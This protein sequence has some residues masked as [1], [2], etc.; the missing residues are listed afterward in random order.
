MTADEEY[1]LVSEM[2][3]DNGGC[4]LPCWWGFTPGETSWQ[5]T[6]ILFTSR[7]KKVWNDV[8]PQNYEIIFDIPDYHYHHQIY[9]EDEKEGVIEMIRVHALPLRGGDGYPV[10][11]N[12][13][14]AEDW[15]FYTSNGRD[16]DFFKRLKI[17]G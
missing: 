10:Y 15:R 3:Q 7:G 1:A 16:L 12:P 11:G 4:R 5:T 6:E 13:Q 9:D 2:L 8:I 14:F 17:P